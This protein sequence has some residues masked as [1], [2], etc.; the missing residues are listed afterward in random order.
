ME[1]EKLETSRKKEELER[2]TRS[3]KTKNERKGKKEE[4]Y[5]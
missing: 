2:V 5:E 1:W 3:R 4:K